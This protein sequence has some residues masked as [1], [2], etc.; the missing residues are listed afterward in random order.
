MRIK[1]KVTN[2]DDYAEFFSC[3]N[4]SPF[5]PYFFCFSLQQA[6]VYSSGMVNGGERLSSGARGQ[7]VD[8]LS[9][10]DDPRWSSDI[11]RSAGVA[12][13]YKPE[14]QPMPDSNRQWGGSSSW[15]ESE[16]G[17]GRFKEN[18]GGLAIAPTASSA[19]GRPRSHAGITLS[20][21]PIP[22]TYMGKEASVVRFDTWD[23]AVYHSF[24]IQFK[25]YEP[26]GVL[27][28]V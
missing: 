5:H 1:Q 3:L 21:V 8:M 14:L 6:S 27:F 18:S 22:V 17:G 2:F 23:F 26:N 28:F 13:E 15:S 25:T 7:R 4:R 24:E 20:Q 10:I 19:S 12:Y 16:R 11:R 9:A